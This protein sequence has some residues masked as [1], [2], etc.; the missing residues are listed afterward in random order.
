MP[1]LIFNVD[2]LLVVIALN[3]GNVQPFLPL[4]EIRQEPMH[5]VNRTF[6]PLPNSK[7]FLHVALDLIIG[8]EDIGHHQAELGKFDERE[9]GEKRRHLI[10][11]KRRAH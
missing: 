11:V 5:F 1:R 4:D 7:L 8:H 6:E 2:A 3:H 10:P 9:I